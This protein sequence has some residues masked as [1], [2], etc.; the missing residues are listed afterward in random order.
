M[1]SMR[2]G[3][4]LW[5]PFG[6]PALVLLQAPAVCLPLLQYYCYCT[7]PLLLIKLT[8]LLLL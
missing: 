8:K 4:G 3:E 5:P 6:S 2:Y 7:T 1:L